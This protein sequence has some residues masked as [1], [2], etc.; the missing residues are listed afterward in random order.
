M[1]ISGIFDWLSNILS[2]VLSP[3]LST[4]GTNF[5]QCLDQGPR[6]LYTPLDLELNTPKPGIAR[7]TEPT[8]TQRIIEGKSNLES[9]DA[10]ISCKIQAVLK[11][12]GIE[13]E[14]DQ[15]DGSVHSSH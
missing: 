4:F 9:Y 10:F 11:H 3:I 15:K 14:S 5:L 1:V 6:I 2:N 8:T 13:V 12:V 7:T